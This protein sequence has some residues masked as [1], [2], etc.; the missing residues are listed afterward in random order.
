[1]Q[2]VQVVLDRLARQAARALLLEVGG[3]PRWVD[4]IDWR[5]PEEALEMT[6]QI[7]PIVLDRRAL[8][9]HHVL[10][11]V[12]VERASIG[13]GLTFGSG[14]DEVVVDPPAQL[15]LRLDPRQAR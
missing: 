13:E 12:D 4:A 6:P 15:A 1:V 14:E 10:E 5:L 7:A 2:E 9:I 8:A 11:M 3:D